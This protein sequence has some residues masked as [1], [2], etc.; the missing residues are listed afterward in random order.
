LPFRAH[1]GQ[2]RAMGDVTNTDAICRLRGRQG[3]TEDWLLFGRRVENQ[4]FFCRPSL[5]GSGLADLGRYPKEA[6]IRSRFLHRLS[7]W[8]C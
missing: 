3:G 1:V 4:T 6:D 5:A 7:Y 2:L 8:L